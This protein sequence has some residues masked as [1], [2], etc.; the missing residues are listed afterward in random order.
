MIRRE[1]VK[2]LRELTEAAGVPGY[3]GEVRDVIR[4]HLTKICSIEQDRLGS[5]VCERK[6][7]RASPKV[8]I[9]GHM[10]E[11]GFMVKLVTDEGFVRFSPLGGWWSHVLLAQRVVIKT[12]R[13]EVP[14]VIGCKPPHI[15]S[16][17]ERKK[18][19]EKK[20]MYI[21]V[22]AESKKQ[23]EEELGVT[24][25]D[26]IIPVCPFTELAPKGLLLGK[27]FDDRV[28]CALFVDAIKRL[29]KPGHPN[30]VYGV[31]T[32]Q[33]EVGTR[34]AHTAAHLIEPD[35]CIVAEVGIAGDVPGVKPEDIQGGLGKGPQICV[36]DGGMIPNLKLRDLIIDVAKRKKIPY[37]LMLLERGATDGAPI[38]KHGTGVPTVYIGVPARHIHSHAGVIHGTDYE[39]TVRLL[40][41]VVQRLNAKTVAD[42]VK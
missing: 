23:A 35:V 15:L 7:R 16:D 28:G 40:V 38:H 42:L 19:V 39:N 5:I 33:E 10:D 41:S 26:P 27:A 3:E 36:L 12:A 22:G 4:R 30:T 2:L 6:G 11:I 34:G 25:G 31:G 9:P 37:Q 1:S 14:G 29:A 20:D 8:M 13:G 18:L 21:D 17:D 32:V 24:V